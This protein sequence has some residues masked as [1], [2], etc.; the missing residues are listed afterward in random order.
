M[1]TIVDISSLYSPGRPSA[2]GFS[3]VNRQSLPGN[4]VPAVGTAS[5]Q[6]TG[7]TGPTSPEDAFLDYMKKT[8]A[9]RFQEQW[10]KAHGLSQAE[11]D[12]MPPEK[13]QAVLDTMRKDLETQMKEKAQNGG[14]KPL[15]ISV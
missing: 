10:L 3:L 13:K 2:A 9:Q 7:P 5:A 6:P 11:F 12:A 14:Q 8:P 4:S 1:R 15:D